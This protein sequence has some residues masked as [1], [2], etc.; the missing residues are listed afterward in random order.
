M[1]SEIQPCVKYTTPAQPTMSPREL[2]AW[3]ERMGK[4]AP[5]QLDLDRPITPRQQRYHIKKARHAEHHSDCPEGGAHHMIID[6]PSGEMV[7][8]GHCKKCGRTRGYYA[9]GEML[10]DTTI[11][12]VPGWDAA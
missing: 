12:V 9:A 8:D 5:A 6:T 2:A 4:A 11:T 7:V 10:T 1:L 3:Y